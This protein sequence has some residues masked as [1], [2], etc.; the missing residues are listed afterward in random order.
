MLKGI[1]EIDVA[2]YFR[3]QGRKIE[4]ENIINSNGKATFII[5]AEPHELTNYYMSEFKK[6]KNELDLIKKMIT[7]AKY[8]QGIYKY[9]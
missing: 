1:Y 2:A 4:I 7:N 3:M 6:F 5:D 9:E 8:N